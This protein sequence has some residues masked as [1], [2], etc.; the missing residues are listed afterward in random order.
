MTDSVTLARKSQATQIVELAEAA[1]LFYDKQG[2]TYATIA[3]N[4]H[5]ETWPIRSK[6]PVA[7]GYGRDG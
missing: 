7:S 3:V 5:F 2:V 1:E 4:A 6:G